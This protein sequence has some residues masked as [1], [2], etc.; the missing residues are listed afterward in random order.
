M[1]G[2]LLHNGQMMV[3]HPKDFAELKTGR[4]TIRP[5]LERIILQASPSGLVELQVRISVYHARGGARIAHEV[6]D[7]VTSSE[8]RAE[9]IVVGFYP[10]T[11]RKPRMVNA[12]LTLTDDSRSQLNVWLDSMEERGL[13]R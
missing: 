6:T 4:P 2:E 8:L 13:I 5:Q 12:V 3:L 7:S 1:L 9:K 11:S 10:F